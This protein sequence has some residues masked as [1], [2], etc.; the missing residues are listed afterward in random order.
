L[1]RNWC[2]SCGAEVEM[3]SLGQARGL[4]QVPP[5]RILA[6]SEAKWLH[7]TEALDGSMQICPLAAEMHME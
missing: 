7:A 6:S 4:A 5:H 2:Q 3:L 1:P